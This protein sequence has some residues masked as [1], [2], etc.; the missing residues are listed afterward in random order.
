[1]VM[2]NDLK[3]YSVIINRKNFYVQTNDSDLKPYKQI[4][5]LTTVQG[6]DYTTGCLLE[7]LCI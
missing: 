7:Y 3:L 5:K 6:E 1:M 4:R 2:L